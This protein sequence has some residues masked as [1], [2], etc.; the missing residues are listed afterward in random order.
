VLALG[1]AP[2]DAEAHARLGGALLAL[3]QP[4]E[5]YR[6]LSFALG[7]RPD[8]LD[9]RRDR[10]VAAYQMQRWPVVVAD[11]TAVLARD[12]FDEW[13]PWWR[14][15]AL[16]HLGLHGSAVLD[17]NNAVPHHP[18]SAKIHLDRARSYAALGRHA[19]AA[20]D[21]N[22]AAELAPND[23]AVL[24]EV[25]WSLVAGPEALRD[26][27]RAVDLARRAVA[28]SP[29]QG[30]MR[31]TL[32]VALYRAG[33]YWDAAAELDKGLELGKGTID[34]EVLYFLAMCHY[35]LDN[36]V[37]AAECLE[38]ANRWVEQRKQLTKE[39]RDQLR[40]FRTEAERELNISPP[41]D[42]P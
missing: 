7:L 1:F 14:A 8:L 36:A 5:A 6:R 41:P 26:P 17:F 20:A 12:P 13:L 10:V 28:R 33:H 4:A 30:Y 23:S 22:K 32:G 3:G 19:E 27:K 31:H 11:V 40:H 29:D 16:Q 15:M 39:A 42:S 9:A 34:A 37:R 25:A 18:G 2:F 21:R 24:N 35:R 38:R